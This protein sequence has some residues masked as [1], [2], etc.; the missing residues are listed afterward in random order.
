MQFPQQVE[1][2]GQEHDSEAS[3]MRVTTV[4]ANCHPTWGLAPRVILKRGSICTGVAGVGEAHELI[5]L[6]RD[7]GL[8]KICVPS[9]AKSVLVSDRAVDV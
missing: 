9:F 2:R 5:V 1:Q 4:R 8:T 7:N 6:E 3:C